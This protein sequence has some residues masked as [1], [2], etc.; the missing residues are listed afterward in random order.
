[1]T[2]WLK[3]LD[4]PTE[5]FI[6]AFAARITEPDGYQGALREA[7]LHLVPRVDWQGYLPQ[8]PHGLL[9]LAAVVELAPSLVEP[10]MLR[11]C[12]TQLQAFAREGRAPEARSLATIGLGS[13]HWPNIDV[14]LREHRPAMAW[15]ELLA[16]EHPRSE[17]F[18]H[19]L[20]VAAPDMANVGHKAV[21]VGAMERLWTS[22]GKSVEV[23]RVLLAWA[24]WFVATEPEDRFWHV[25]MARRTSGVPVPTGVSNQGAAWQQS[26]AHEICELGLV[27]MLDALAARMKAGATAGDLLA[28]L[29]LAASEK[30]LDARRDM[31]G[32]TAWNLAYL[33]TLGRD[34]AGLGQ[35]EVWGQAA[36]M[37]NFFPSD[38]PEDRYRWQK[39]AVDPAVLSTALLEAILDGD[40]DVAMDLAASSADSTKV[41][42]ACAEAASRNDPGFNRSSH[43]LAAAG[44]QQLLSFLPAWVASTMLIALAKSL[45]NSQGSDDLGRVADREL[46]R[47]QPT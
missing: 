38:A 9:G 42:E 40:P 29:V 4:S 5:G 3:E 24:G 34:L 11:L 18:H 30:M 27:G 7:L 1:M 47:I 6:P 33:A 26:L 2:P 35:P 15:G 21:A 17:D 37:V 19:L 22:L 32:K 31:E 46:G 45:A 25:R 23:G 43:V 16:L 44:A 28:G 10:S 8:V 20:C 36:A 12:A 39:R 13:G 41:M 14:A